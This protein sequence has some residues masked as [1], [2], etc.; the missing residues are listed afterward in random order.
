DS[1]RHAQRSKALHRSRHG[2]ILV[3]A[4]RRRRIGADAGRLRRRPSGAGDAIANR[5]R[6]HHIGA[7]TINSE[8]IGA[9]ELPEITSSASREFH[10]ARSGPNQNVTRTAIW[11]R[12]GG[13][14]EFG[15]SKAAL[16]IWPAELN[17]AFVFRP[18]NWVWLK[19]L[20][21]S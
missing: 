15:V 20:Y 8:R 7:A 6:D 13:R 3:E 9:P 11:I 17:C 5:S 14:A 10:R 19:A 16:I 21:D 4:A 2:R 1:S 12:R 18:L